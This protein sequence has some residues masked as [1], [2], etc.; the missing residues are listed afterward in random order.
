MCVNITMKL[1]HEFALTEGNKQREDFASSF[2]HHMTLHPEISIKLPVD[3][4]VV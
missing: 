1:K 3:L 2:H 4:G